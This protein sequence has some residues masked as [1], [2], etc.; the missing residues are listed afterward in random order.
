MC[1]AFFSP[2]MWTI[3]PLFGANTTYRPLQLAKYAFHI[4]ETDTKLCPQIRECG[5]VPRNAEF[6]C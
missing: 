5:A 1:I 2:H 3:T 6:C 4:Y